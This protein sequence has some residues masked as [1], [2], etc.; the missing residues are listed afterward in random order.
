MNIRDFAGR[1]VPSRTLGLGERIFW[2]YGADQDA[3]LRE[4]TPRLCAGALVIFHQPKSTSRWRINVITVTEWVAQL[5]G[6]NCWPLSWDIISAS[7]IKKSVW[8]VN[9]YGT[10]LKYCFDFCLDSAVFN[11]LSR[12]SHTYP[13]YPI[14]SCI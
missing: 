2:T 12:T 1:R 6:N 3:I 13:Y 5:A 4:I 11:W 7:I 14:H 8:S 9:I 10:S